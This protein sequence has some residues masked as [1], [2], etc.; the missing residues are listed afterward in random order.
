MINRRG[1]RALNR[2]FA[3]FGIF[4]HELN[5]EE[6]HK[7]FD[8][9]GQIKRVC[10]VESYTA[11]FP[12]EYQEEGDG[13]AIVHLHFNCPICKKEG[14]GTEYLA[15]IPEIGDEFYCENCGT[16]FVV[17]KGEDGLYIARLVER[18]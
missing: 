9:I 18:G 2:H 10:K 15:H 8:A 1:N 16:E 14:V 13:Y 11:T 17:L 6:A 12:F 3:F 4:E 7:I 5:T